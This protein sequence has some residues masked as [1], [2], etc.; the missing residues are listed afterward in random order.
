MGSDCHV[1]V[2]GGS[3]GLASRAVALVDGLEARW[4]RFLPDSEVSRLNAAAGSPVEV[5]A[6]TITLVSRAVEA[7][8]LT[9]GRFD[10]TV[11][12]AVVRAGYDR[13]FSELGPF[14]AASSVLRTGCDGIEVDPAAGTVRLPY[15]VGFDPGGIG[16]GLAADVV[17]A[18]LLDAGAAG[19]CVNL[20]GDLR[21]AG[22]SPG[23]EAW[24]VAVEHELTHTVVA[25]VA[26]TGGAVATSSTARRRWRTRDGEAHHLIDPFTGA[27]ARAGLVAVTAVAAEGWQAEVLAKAA[28]VAGPREALPLVRAFG[29]E[30]LTVD[31]TGAVH[32]TAALLPYLTAAAA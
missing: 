17:V 9:A 18:S 29:A 8:H 32:T 28:L 19:A 2:V 31:E 11:L 21:V 20:G 30:A 26:V 15:G 25:T 23:G 10:P 16:K 4:S 12:G 27:P 6:D 3:A 1:I 14:P 13:S 7:W 5:S 22:E 24:Q